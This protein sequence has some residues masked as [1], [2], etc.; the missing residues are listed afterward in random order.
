MILRVAGLIFLGAG[1][2]MLAAAVL[3]LD[4]TAL[5]ANI[6]AG[7]LVVAGIPIGVLGLILTTTGVILDLSRRRR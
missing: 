6:G 4:P 2:V 5:D 1:F 3:I 7:I